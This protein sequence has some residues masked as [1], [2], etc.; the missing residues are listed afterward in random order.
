VGI[1]L[2]LLAFLAFIAALLLLLGEGER[3]DQAKVQG[4]LRVLSG[5]TLVLDRPVGQ[6]RDLTPLQLQRSL[7][8]VP[9]SRR[10]RRG[11]AEVALRT[12][13]RALRRAVERTLRAG[14][15]TVEVPER[16]VAAKAR[17]PIVKQALRNNCETAA[18][19]MLL[20]T[21]GRRVDQLKL[22]RQLPRSGPLD[23]QPGAELD[24][25]GDPDK[26]FVGRPEGGGTSGGYGVYAD[27]VRALAR[28]HAVKLVDLSGG[29]ARASYARL[30]SGRP[31]MTWVGL[32]EGP[33][34]TWRTPNGK[35]ITGNFGEQTVVLT[36]IRGGA[37]AVNDPLSGR[38]LTWTRRQFEQMWQRLGR[39]AL[40]L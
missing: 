19:S 30:L 39:R 33:Y 17:V 35:R 37:V 36:G 8:R 15:G 22:Q 28:R 10:E 7:S 27:P 6:L 1:W 12:D 16:A 25:W 40:A 20:A 29:S 13:G 32:S 21:R 26:G 31:V 9:R 34:E 4:R 14:G 18:L 3:G 24:L 23:P 5:P 38:R 11:V 2:A